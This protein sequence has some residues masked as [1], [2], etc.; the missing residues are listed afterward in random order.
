MKLIRSMLNAWRGIKYSFT[1]QTN[2]KIH[3]LL[4]AIVLTAGIWLNISTIEWMVVFICIAVVLTTELLNTAIEKLADV[5]HLEIHPGIKLVKDIAAGAVLVCAIVS[6]VIAT[7]VFLPKI[8][9]LV[10]PVQ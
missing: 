8:L 1:T 7:I 9:H 4:S 2:F 5:V 6:F 3:L 10:K